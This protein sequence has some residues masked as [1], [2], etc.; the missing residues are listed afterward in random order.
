MPV[1]RQIIMPL[2]LVLTVLASGIEG[3][4]RACR[5]SPAITTED[6]VYGYGYVAYATGENG[7]REA[8]LLMDVLRPR[9][10][11][12]GRPGVV[13]VHGGGFEGGSRRDDELV[14]LAEAL[15]EQ[16]YVCF[17][18]D[19]RLH[20]DRPPAPEPYAGG[21]RAAAHAAAVDVKAAVRHVHAQAARYGVDTDRISLLGESA[22]AIAAVAAAVSGPGSFVQDGDAFPIPAGSTPGGSTALRAVISC[23]GNGAEVLDQFDAADPPMMIV[24]GTADEN[25]GT[26]YSGAVAMSERC[27]EVGIPHVLY[28]I[29]GAGHGPWDA[30]VGGFDLAALAGAFLGQHAGG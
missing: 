17:L 29:E 30:E 19:Y 1:L 5:P 24:H 11:G 21:L 7:Y 27:A 13:M 23:W 3:C 25:S 26:P 9:T 10:A 18:I 12:A 16:G 4:P 8:P 22:G 6:V 14:A 15:V 20:G 2:L 28:S